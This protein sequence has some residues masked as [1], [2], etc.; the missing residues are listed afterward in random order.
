MKRYTS[1]LN[2]FDDEDFTRPSVSAN[3]LMP[4]RNQNDRFQTD[5][6][7]NGKTRYE[8]E[9]TIIK[10]LEEEIVNMKHKLSFVYEKDEEISKL[11]EQISKLKKD[12]KAL[13]I[14]SKDSSELRIKNKQLRDELDVLH[15][16]NT[17]SDKLISENRLLKVKL[18][19]LSKDDELSKDESSLLEV[20]YTDDIEGI[21]DIDVIEEMIDINIPHLRSILTHRLKDK[22][23]QHIDSLIHR[24]GLRK[25]N[26]V[27][28]SVM[29]QLLEEAIHL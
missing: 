21:E 29:E 5:A 1:N 8:E 26:K 11:K 7:I 23:S 3:D 18:K 25:T 15:L 16:Q 9:N 19:E 12:I 13:E 6:L 14:M 20:D 24:Y 10:S 22:Q 17:S 28:R 4:I 2:I 27:K